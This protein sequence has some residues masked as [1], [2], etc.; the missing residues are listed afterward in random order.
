MAGRK[1]RGMLRMIAAM[2][3]EGAGFD[4]IDKMIDAMLAFRLPGEE[5]DAPSANGTDKA[6]VRAW[7]LPRTE[8]QRCGARTRKG[9]PCKRPVLA[10]GRC[11]NHGGLSSGPKT[12]AGRARIAK[13]QIKRW[14]LYRAEKNLSTGPRKIRKANS[15]LRPCNNMMFSCFASQ[16]MRLFAK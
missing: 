8:R 3:R 10:N 4:E 1:N 11:P 7:R 2:A 13:A 12:R 6:A 16:G 14:Q 9:S 5:T 15:L